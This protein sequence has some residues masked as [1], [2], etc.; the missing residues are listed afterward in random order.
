VWVFKGLVRF[1][2]F[3]GFL[4]R[5]APVP[6]LLPCFFLGLLAL[7]Q[8]GYLPGVLVYAIGFLSVP[9]VLVLL[10]GF[11]SARDIVFRWDGFK[12]LA[13]VFFSFLW[14]IYRGIYI[15]PYR[16]KI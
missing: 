16:D 13:T 9:R 14:C 5:A 4:P 7:V 11:R 1:G 6:I 3:G 10:G 8:K 15:N 12:Y 2:G